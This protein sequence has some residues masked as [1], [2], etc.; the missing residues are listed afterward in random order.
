MN[1]LITELSKIEE[2]ITKTEETL[3]R[4]KNLH[5]KITKGNN[6]ELTKKIQHQQTELTSLK[7]TRDDL[8]RKL[9]KGQSIGTIDRQDMPAK[10]TRKSS[11]SSISSESSSSSRSSRAVRDRENDDEDSHVYA[12]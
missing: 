1:R 8:L 10:T 9:N 12:F 5:T 6:P 2:K 7:K 4:L 3:R 11:A